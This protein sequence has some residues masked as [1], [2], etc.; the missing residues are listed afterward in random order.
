MSLKLLLKNLPLRICVPTG[1]GLNKLKKKIPT[2]EKVNL[3]LVTKRLII[4]SLCIGDL[5][6]L[7][8]AIYE[9]GFNSV[10]RK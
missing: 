1:D 2:R 6:L 5:N 9:L 4:K 10:L 8:H 3:K 7:Q